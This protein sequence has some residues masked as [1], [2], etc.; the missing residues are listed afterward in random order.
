MYY[1]NH[2]QTLQ[3]TVMYFRFADDFA[4]HDRFYLTSPWHTAYNTCLADKRSI[5]EFR[6]EG[7]GGNRG[8]QWWMTAERV[9]LLRTVTAAV[10]W[11]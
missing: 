7:E 5:E 9:V 11:M 2:S 10:V 8:R 4:L 3:K 1:L 6:G